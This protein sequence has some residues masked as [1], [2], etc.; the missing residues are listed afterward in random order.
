MIT[1]AALLQTAVLLE[2]RYQTIAR[3]PETFQVLPAG[4]AQKLGLGSR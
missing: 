2:P 3:P 4:A 1:S